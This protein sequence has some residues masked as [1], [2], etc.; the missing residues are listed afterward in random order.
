MTVEVGDVYHGKGGY[1]PKYWLIVSI[2]DYRGI[3]GK[4]ACM[5]GLDSLE[6]PEIVSA[7]TYS[8]HAFERRELVT[9]IDMSTLR[10][11]P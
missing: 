1:K 11:V 3:H 6:E 10:F 2:Y 7:Q 8:V 9:K 5:L 4:R